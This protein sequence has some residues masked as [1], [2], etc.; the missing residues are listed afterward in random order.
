MKN[1]SKKILTIFVFILLSSSIY[2]LAS[3][4]VLAQENTTLTVF[5]AVQDVKVNPGESTRTQIQFRNGSDNLVTGVVKVADFIVTDKKG[6]TE[7]V[8]DPLLRPKYSAAAWIKISDNTVAIPKNEIVTENLYI[9]PPMDLTSCGYYA[10]VYFQPDT[11]ITKTLG[12]QK[13]SASSINSKIGGLINFIVQN[14]KCLENVSISRLDS[15]IFSEYGPVNV[16]FDLLNLGDIHESPKGT[17]MLTD[18]FGHY[19]DQQSIKELR[20]FPEKAK[21]YQLSLGQKWLMGRFKI[22]VL[23]SYGVDN[24]ITIERSVLVWVFP[25][26]I[27]LAVVL[28]ILIIVYISSNLYKRMVVKE[29]SLE[30]ELA[31]EKQELEKLKQ[32]LHKRE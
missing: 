17:V 21:E 16:S 1:I 2:H 25:W 32:Q 27:A 15:P 19:V 3:N 6:T 10:I 22:N 5:P 7:L 29:D 28:A 20:I 13:Q 23:A 8:E 4:P 12:A 18:L 30:K 26:R 11:S 31:K 24:P 14:K 9:S